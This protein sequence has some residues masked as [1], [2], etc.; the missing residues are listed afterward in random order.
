MTHSSSGPKGPV[1]LMTYIKRHCAKC[2]HGGCEGWPLPPQ[3]SAHGP[4]VSS[5]QFIPIERRSALKLLLV[6]AFAGWSCAE[7]TITS[8]ISEDSNNILKNI[9]VISSPLRLEADALKAGQT[10]RASVTYTNRGSTPRNIN[11]FIIALRP[12]G[13]THNG[14]PFMDMTPVL[15]PITLAPNESITLQALRV[16][17]ATDPL[18]DWESYPSFRDDSGDWH[19]GPAL[20]VTVLSPNCVPETCASEGKNCGTV[21]NGCGGSLTCGGCASPQT[22]GGGGVANVCGGSA[23]PVICGDAVCSPSETCSSCASDC[24]SCPPPPVVCGDAVCSS[25]ETCSSCALD[26]GACPPPPV[27]CGDAVCSSTETCST[28]ALDCGA[29]PPPPVVCGD[30]ICS[31]TETCSTCALDCG[32]CPPP[33]VVCGDAVCSPSETCSTCASDCGACPPPPVV[34]GDAVCSSSETCSSCASD[35]GACPSPITL[36]GNSA[37]GSVAD[38]CPPGEAEA[39]SY[40]AAASGKVG[41]IKIFIDSNNSATTVKLGIYTDS[42][43]L[44]PN[45][46]CTVTSPVAH[47]WNTCLITNGPTVTAGT[48]YWVA[49]LTPVGA[50]TVRFR[51]EQGGIAH[52]SSSNTLTS[53]RRPTALA[54]PGSARR[55][56][57]SCFQYRSETV[58]FASG[59]QHPSVF[60]RPSAIIDRRRPLSVIVEGCAPW[61]WQV[62]YGCLTDRI[63]F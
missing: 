29:C 28:C 2:R 37:V 17:S 8:D 60:T 57:S 45:G 61:G 23:P 19:D 46:Q 30:S 39:F 27:L 58:G 9:V 26:C 63:S 13:G 52:A 15:G 3:E 59:C 5:A 14:G 41:G 1:Q 51:N 11:Q 18:G 53:L 36:F 24:G 38:Y 33:P 31:P 56:R 54:P 6:F 44:L 35:C 10:L 47:A 22:C 49:I 34:C 50:G 43:T 20:N 32:A 40:T 4:F 25:S 55:P 48:V 21:S 62:V 7:Y 42:S 16:F 12:P